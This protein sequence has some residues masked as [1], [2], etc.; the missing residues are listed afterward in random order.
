VPAIP[1]AHWQ[2]VAE[3]LQLSSSQVSRLCYAYEQFCRCV[4]VAVGFSVHI[5]AVVVYVVYVK[6]TAAGKSVAVRLC[7]AYEQFCRCQCG[8]CCWLVSAHVRCNRVVCAVCCSSQVSWL[9]Y[10]YEQF[11]RC[12]IVAVGLCAWLLS[13]CGGCCCLVH[14]YAVVVC[15]HCAV[16]HRQVCAV[17]Q[18]NA[19]GCALAACGGV[20]AAE[21]QPSQPAV[22]HV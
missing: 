11:C 8:G 15:C 1:A 22:L 3:S 7:Y 20:S 16:S 6:C 2:R 17:L 18:P 10:A 12:V 21:Q 19:V 4:I 5:Y 14:M 13:L 9:C